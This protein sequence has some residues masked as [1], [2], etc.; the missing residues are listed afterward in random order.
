MRADFGDPTETSFT[1]GGKEIWRYKY[2]HMTSKVSDF[3]PVVNLFSSGTNVD[4]RELVFLFND[5]GIVEN[6]AMQSSK[7]EVK[8]GILP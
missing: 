2:S 6:Y 5:N 4:K 3:I 8:S 7:E 1:D